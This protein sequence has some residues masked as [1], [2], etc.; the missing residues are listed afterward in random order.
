MRVLHSALVPSHPQ[1]HPF[2]CVADAGVGA[3]A[4]ADWVVLSFAPRVRSL[5]WIPALP[6]FDIARRRANEAARPED[7]GV[8]TAEE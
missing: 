8:R 4:T 5:L 3:G 6:L 2:F 1:P 7:A